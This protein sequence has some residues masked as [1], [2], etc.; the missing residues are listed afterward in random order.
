MIKTSVAEKS[1]PISLRRTNAAELHQDTIL[2]NMEYLYRVDTHIFACILH[3]TNTM[4]K[5]CYNQKRE[6]T[7]AVDESLT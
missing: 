7:N 4:N 1:I 3:S 2:N 5:L 6:D